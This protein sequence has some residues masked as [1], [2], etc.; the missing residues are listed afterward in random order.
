[1]SES[2]SLSDPPNA[3][4]KPLILH[5]RIVNGVGGGPEKTILNSPRFLRPLGFDS[6]CLYLYPDGDRGI[7]SLQQSATENEAELIAWPDGSA[8]DFE[9]VE[10]LHQFCRQRNVAIWHAHDYKTNVLGLLVRRKWPMK[11]VTTTHGWCITNRKSWCYATAGRIC[12]PFYDSVIAVS[13]DLYRSGRRWGLYRDHVQLISNAIDTKDYRRDTSSKEARQ[14]FTNQNPVSAPSDGSFLIVALGRLTIEKGFSYLIDAVD[15]LCKEK[16]PVTLWI[17]GEGP[18]R[19]DLE[20]QIERLGLA[21][22]VTL[23]GHVA[24]PRTLLQTADA[25]VLSSVTEGLPNVLLEAMSL[26]VPI[27]STNVGGIARLID[28]RIHGLL[29]ASRQPDELAEAV[30]ELIASKHLQERM[31]SA[32]RTRIENEFDFGI[33]MQKIAAIYQR[34]LNSHD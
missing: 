13:E 1:M 23:L 29:V 19:Q 18:L 30:E 14:R 9:M 33:R 11:L 28:D 10:K 17:G 27:V 16:I 5:T 20:G 12:L 32:A 6:A 22:H 7:E 3:K 26:E 4:P 31:T 2:I 25:F 24:D 21:D 15:L 8:I 34:L